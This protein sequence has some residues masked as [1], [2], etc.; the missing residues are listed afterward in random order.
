MWQQHISFLREICRKAEIWICSPTLNLTIGYTIKIINV[1]Q[2]L[3]Y[4][5]SQYW[6]GLEVQCEFCSLHAMNILSVSETGNRQPAGCLAGSTRPVG[7]MPVRWGLGRWACQLN[8]E[9]PP[10]APPPLSPSRPPSFPLRTITAN[11]NRKW[12]EEEVDLTRAI[13]L[14]ESD[15]E[16]KGGQRQA[17]EREEIENTASCG[18]VSCLGVCPIYRISQWTL[19]LLFVVFN[20]HVRNHVSIVSEESFFTPLSLTVFICYHPGFLNHFTVTRGWFYAKPVAAVSGTK[21]PR[22]CYHQ[23]SHCYFDSLASVEASWSAA[24]S[25]FLSIFLENVGRRLALR[26][27]GPFL[28]S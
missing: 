28:L 6:L 1:G 18:M 11:R 20:S 27:S 7:V 10:P 12:C 21:Y 14:A 9:T 19:T 4:R 24:V 25:P 17:R 3:F 5:K 22:A 13:P 8:K 23:H 2:T 16:R 15:E 26:V